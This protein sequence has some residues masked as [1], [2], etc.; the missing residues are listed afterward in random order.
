[1]LSV[2]E[3]VKASAKY[4]ITQNDVDSAVVTNTADVSGKSLQNDTVT[5]SDDAATTI[6][7]SP[8]ISLR[9][10]VDK[11]TLTGDAAVVGTTLTYDFVLT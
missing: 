2:G 10:D 1:M 4:D 3:T 11:E 6:E 7:H 9:K 8:S 5:D